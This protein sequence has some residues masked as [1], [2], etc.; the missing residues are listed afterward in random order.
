MPRICEFYGIV[1]RMYHSEAHGLPHFHASYQGDDVVI[2]VQT[3]DVLS[4]RI[5]PRALK[6]VR[7]WA[8]GH[9][10]E[11]LEDWDRARRHLALK[12]IP[13]LD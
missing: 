2:A 13:P 1:I 11:L 3:L 9:R 5:A 12:P 10:T 7:E 6:L 8:R 4:G